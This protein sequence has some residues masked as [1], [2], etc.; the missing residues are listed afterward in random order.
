M[1]ANK[2]YILHIVL[3]CFGTLLFLTVITSPAG[4]IMIPVLY[5]VEE[6]QAWPANKSCNN[7][8]LERLQK[9][10]KPSLQI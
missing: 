1:P 9:Q 3:A 7:A 10:T 8:P 2:L 6:E 5:P 4:P